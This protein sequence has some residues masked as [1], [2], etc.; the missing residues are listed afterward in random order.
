MKEK[1]TAQDLLAD[2]A[3]TISEAVKWS[4]VG[5][6]RLY[7]AMNDGRLPYVQSGT[8]RLIPRKALRSFL[9]AGLIND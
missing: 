1:N 8:R 9:V 4:G 6:T 5:R 3:M 7:A 2:G